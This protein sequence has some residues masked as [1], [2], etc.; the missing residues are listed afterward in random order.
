MHA[1]VCLSALV[2]INSESLWRGPPVRGWRTSA[3]EKDNIIFR[4]YE[5][6]A[7]GLFH[8]SAMTTGWPI[9]LV[10]NDNGQWQ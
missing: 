9:P 7:A 2:Y 3:A 4:I 1:I 5:I 6:H 10:G 8:S